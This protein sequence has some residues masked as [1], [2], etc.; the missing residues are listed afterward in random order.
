MRLDRRIAHK[1]MESSRCSRFGRWGARSRHRRPR[2]RRLGWGL[3]S[4]LLPIALVVSGA[5]LSATA[6]AAATSPSPRF[7]V[8]HLTVDGRT[9]PVGTGSGGPSFAWQITSRTPGTLQR[10]YEVEVG[11]PTTRGLARGQAGA[12]RRLGPIIW[13][14]GRVASSS[15]V[16]VA[17]GGPALEPSTVYVW[18]VRVWGNH[19]QVSAWS[20][21]AWWE[22]GLFTPAD[23]SGAKW[24]GGEPPPGPPA[25]PAGT[26]ATASSYHS[27]CCG[28][29]YVPQNAID[30]NTA[31]YWNSAVAGQFPVWL[32]ISSPSALS[33]PGVSILSNSNGY[34]TDFSVA[35]WNGSAWVT[36]AQV[37]KATSVFTEVHF[38]S[39]VTTTQVRITV[40][41][42]E[43]TPLG[44]Y[45]RINEVYPGFYDPLV[46]PKVPAPE[47]RTTFG[48]GHVPLA[49]A[50]LYISA[51]GYEVPYVNG[52]RVGDHQLDPG[53]TVYNDRIQYVTYDV[54]NLV[55]PGQNAL[56]AVLGNGFYDLSAPD[57]WNWNDSPWT[58]PPRLLAKLVLTYANG[59]QQVVVSDGA[60]HTHASPTRS[61]SVYLG[62]TYDALDR[63]PGWDTPGYDASSWAAA[64]VLPAPTTNV[65]PETQPPIT[66]QGV[67]KATTITNP[68]P[69]VYVYKFPDVISGWARLQV[70]GPAGTAVH[71]EY[72]QV[73]NA[74]GT[75]NGGQTVY[76]GVQGGI[77]TYVLDGKGI[78]T[79]QPRFSYNS[80]QY[81]QVTGYPG[82]PTSSSVEA[83]ALHSDVPTVGA[84]SSSNPLLDE[85]YAMQQRTIANNLY[86]IPTASPTWGKNGWLGDAQLAAPGAMDIFGMET[87]Y[88]NW[89]RDI[90]DSQAPSG[91]LPVI[92]PDNGWG[93]GS[94]APEWSAALPIIAWDSYLNYGNLD[95][96]SENYPSMVAYLSYLQETTPSL[97][98]NTSFGDWLSPAFPESAR[99][100]S[101]NEL[102]ATAYV[103]LDAQLMAKIATAL[104][105]ARAA[106]SYAQLA[107]R[108]TELINANFLDPATGYYHGATLGTWSITNGLLDTNGGGTGLLLGG[109]SWTDY[110]MSFSVAIDADQSGWAVR[111]QGPGNKYLLILDASNDVAGPPN[112]LQELVQHN[113]S[114][115]PVGQVQLPFAVTPGT[116]YQVKIVASG[117]TVTTFID[118]S[119]VASFD[120]TD[121]P[122]GVSG[123]GSGTV[124]FRENTD[125]P[126]VVEQ[127]S[128]AD[129]SVTAPDGTVLYQNALRS[130][131]AL[132]DFSEPQAIMTLQTPDAL[133]LAFGLTPPGGTAATVANLVANVHAA[134]DH[135]DTGILGTSA[136]L[137]ALSA[138]GHTNLAYAI[139]TQTTYPSW[140]DWVEQGLTTDPGDAWQPVPGDHD[141]WSSIVNWLYSDLVGIT[142]TSP[143][144]GTLTIEPY[145]PA[146]LDQARA[147]I[148]TVRGKVAASWAKSPGGG[149]VL[150]VTIPAN[151]TA[152]VEVPATTGSSVSVDGRSATAV[153]GVRVSGRTGTRA[154]FTVGSGS[155]WFTVSR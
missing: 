81:V 92:A 89:L 3:L 50:W 53:Y 139:A 16:D 14:S 45:A 70:Q 46:P 17:Y 39:P 122:A 120:A 20:S 18:R 144:Y 75:V 2:L 107:Q 97:L 114:Y 84:F 66:V 43:N 35:T 9:D 52:E 12:P 110:T 138:S 21:P 133:A 118:G 51:G 10:V 127:A 22:T 142:A 103:D 126:T 74:N 11:R 95:V 154:I 13:R 32:T 99:P 62:E 113:G 4:L 6:T 87:F 83:V 109:S 152:T 77:D 146:A 136:L 42:A 104:G 28:L 117:P 34:P 94:S 73:L 101:G 116:W 98:F 108:I 141:M 67:Y 76:D 40:D 148:D 105:H 61:D 36:Q 23:W 86:G 130:P 125:S 56:G 68:Q 54:R 80:F 112:T 49:S 78:E 121:F 33:L 137:P 58:G 150:R 63:T 60:W 64:T 149:L 151:S 85:I 135:L 41:A 143:G 1:S 65:V 102:T 93:L 132:A 71:L 88:A 90:V 44:D 31:T 38:P 145:V 111:A 91:Q 57:P 96:L 37:S 140:G 115:T 79:W 29:T 155:Y 69:G 25:W 72:S 129:L 119:Q 5:G 82:T 26:T 106:A 19:G 123:F 134:G 100:L 30:G 59:R 128:Y 124:G 48:V 7:A 147:S 15:S 8:S 47:L 131:E 27:P 153:P 55:H 24:I